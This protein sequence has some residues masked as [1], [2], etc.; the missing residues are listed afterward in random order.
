MHRYLP[1]VAIGKKLL[2]IVEKLFV[3][4]GG[5]LVVRSL[6]YRI[7]G[8]SFLAKS[9]INAFSHIDVIASSLSAPI[10]AALSFDSDGLRGADGFTKLACYASLFATAQIFQL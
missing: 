8:T 9:T 7:N 5:E 6:N 3:R 10:G 2:L 4:L 1:L